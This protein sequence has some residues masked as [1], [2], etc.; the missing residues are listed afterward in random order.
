MS[1]FEIAGIVLG[2][3]P[4]AISALEGYRDLA[5]RLGLYY[6]IRLE[7]KN[8][9]D[10]LEINKIIFTRHLSQLLLPLIV[11]DEK[12][13]E[14]LSEPGGDCWKEESIAASLERR[15]QGSYQLYMQYIQYMKRTLDEINTELAIDSD[16]AKRLLDH[17]QASS[18]RAILKGL[19]TR[20]GLA[21]HIHKF[22]LSNSDSIRKR[23]FDELKQN[24][25]RLEMLLRPLPSVTLT[26]MN[27]IPPLSYTSQ[28]LNLCTAFRTPDMA[29]YGFLADDDIR[30]Y[31]HNISQP[32]FKATTS[33]TLDQ[34]L[35]GETNPVFTH[36]DP[37]ST[38]KHSRH[39]ALDHLGIRL[40]ELCFGQII[41]DQPWRKALPAGG[42]D[43]E[44]TCYDILA[45]REWLGHVN[46]EAGPAYADAVSWCLLGNRSVKLDLSLTGKYIRE[47]TCSIEIWWGL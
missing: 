12:I 40:L 42:N 20:D 47:D 39:V 3:F 29:C 2:A 38:G 30:Y 13:R 31:V 41:D 17:P 28:I 19:I 32:D 7:Y 14:L 37:T 46:D 11:D 43:T 35:R 10:E 1:G 27:T 16:W 26:S 22:K 8:W 18:K 9:L 24:N 45:A 5:K 15:L 21:L 23:L 25:D 34:I 44:K 6:K 4:I 33:V 36:N